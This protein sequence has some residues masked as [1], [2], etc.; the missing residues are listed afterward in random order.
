MMAGEG[1][2]LDLHE[3]LFHLDVWLSAYDQYTLHP[4]APWLQIQE[5]ICQKFAHIIDSEINLSP[6]RSQA[7]VSC[8]GPQFTLKY[9]SYP[10]HGLQ[11]KECSQQMLLEMKSLLSQGLANA[12]IEA[13]YGSLVTHDTLR[14]KPHE[15]LQQ[16][17][18]ETALQFKEYLYK[19]CQNEEL[20]IM[21]LKHSQ[22]KVS[23]ALP[24]PKID[25]YFNKSV[26][27]EKLTKP[28]TRKSGTKI[29]V[30]TE[31][32]ETIGKMVGLILERYPEKIT[33]VTDK[34]KGFHL[35]ANLRKQIWTEVLFQNVNPMT[36]NQSSGNLKKHFRQQFGQKLQSNLK[37]LHIKH[38]LHSPIKD[39]IENTVIETYNK[40]PSMQLYKSTAYMKEASR[41][42]NALYIYNQSYQPF[43]VLW[44][45]PMQIALADLAD[46]NSTEGEEIYELAMLL[47]LLE[48]RC[49]PSWAIMSVIAENVM[50]TLELK[51]LELYK[52][53]KHVATIN[54]QVNPKDCLVHLMEEERTLAENLVLSKSTNKIKKTSKRLPT[55]RLS[56]AQP[57]MF[58][59][60]WIGEAFVG[61]LDLAAMLWVWDQLFLQCW[62]QQVFHDICIALVALL[63][64]HFLVASDYL[65]MKQVFVSQTFHLLTLDIQRAYLAVIKGSTSLHDIA[66]LN[67]CSPQGVSGGD[68]AATAGIMSEQS[69]KS[70]TDLTKKTHKL[71]IK[72]TTEL[73]NLFIDFSKL[74]NKGLS[75]QIS[76]VCFKLDFQQSVLQKGTD[77][78]LPWRELP[79]TNK[80][81][82]SIIL[83]FGDECIEL[84]KVQSSQISF[85]TTPTITG[86]LNYIAKVT[87]MFNFADISVSNYIDKMTLGEYFHL[88][89]MVVYVHKNVISTLGWAFIPLTELTQRNTVAALHSGAIPDIFMQQHVRESLNCTET[90][91]KYVLGYNSEI[92]L[93]ID[94]RTETAL[95]ASD[96]RNSGSVADDKMGKS[97]DV[98]DFCIYID[99]LQMLPDNAS[100]VK[101]VSYLVQPSKPLTTKLLPT[102]PSID[103]KWCCPMFVPEDRF[104]MLRMKDNLPKDTFIL[105]TV[106]T[107]DMNSTQLCTLGNALMCLCESYNDN[108]DVKFCSGGYQLK[109]RSGSLDMSKNI[110]SSSL[111]N[112]PIVPVVS[113][114]IRILPLVQDVQPAPPYTS[115][116]YH[117][118]QCKPTVSEERIFKSFQKHSKLSE[119]L[120]TLIR[121]LQLSDGIQADQT[122][123][124]MM[125]W[126]KKKLD[127]DHSIQPFPVLNVN[128]CVSYQSD[129][130]LKFTIDKAFNLKE[131]DL[132]VQCVTQVISGG[133]RRSMPE[134]HTSTTEKYFMTLKQDIDCHLHS[135][136]WQDP[137]TLIHPLF[138][139]KTCLLIQILGLKILSPNF[140]QSKPLSPEDSEEIQL[141]PAKFVCWTAIN[142]FDGKSVRNGHHYL[143]LLSGQPSEEVLLQLSNMSAQSVFSTLHPGSCYDHKEMLNTVGQVE[144]YQKEDFKGTQHSKDWRDTIRNLIEEN[145]KGNTESFLQ[146]LN[147]FE[148]IVTNKLEHFMINIS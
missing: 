61:K 13:G 29:K 95:N 12:I 101:V 88:I 5:N 36:N 112:L 48:S 39:L 21:Q 59:R 100:I 7:V 94:V 119:P 58:I 122:E 91:S 140:Q 106:Y 8:M 125:E 99:S 83:K 135:P 97:N 70:I 51:D 127:T 110:K 81:L 76:D 41:V 60:Q 24:E 19:F 32:S 82:M 72:P 38:P 143:P 147:D 22:P 121:R 16:F 103:S 80:I 25:Y 96:S 30:C 1:K 117:S 63:R 53:L 141:G 15:L 102:F 133:Q 54:A 33:V 114:L 142:I 137:T 115:N 144:D 11:H 35:P 108:N 109:L 57:I 66:S 64:E 124:E 131:K 73:S 118:I 104:I 116:Y 132:F 146:K 107:I 123:F 4:G 84:K 20:R 42:L 128:Q 148:E 75:I 34:L 67:R 6:E 23:L 136:V 89:V 93:K 78:N 45:F 77:K 98:K 120:R 111:D 90:S 49:F 10:S 3:S 2:N 87:D 145:N 138:D 86:K 71:D 126:C 9:L 113:L 47:H 52:H 85:Q 27:E 79:E 43:Y 26:A 14:E 31:D 46:K 40:T 37:K 56:L 68:I 69:S 17:R 139:D 92:F 74:S 62:H 105:F 130:G 65:Q 134:G 50:A 129:I 55:T 28:D 18:R 44:L